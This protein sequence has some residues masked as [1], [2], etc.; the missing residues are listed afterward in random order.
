MK[1]WITRERLND[2]HIIWPADA[3]LRIS[4]GEAWWDENCR[5][6]GEPISF[7]AVDTLLGQPVAKGQKVLIDVSICAGDEALV[8]DD[9]L[10]AEC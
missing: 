7:A 4:K 6:R 9:T 5:H 2:E 10:I 8:G 1:F 3:V